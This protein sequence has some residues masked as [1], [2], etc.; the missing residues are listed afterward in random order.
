LRRIELCP[1]SWRLAKEA[2]AN[3]LDMPSEVADRGAMLHRAALGFE[4]FGELDAYDGSLV[5]RARAFITAELE[6]MGPCEICTEHRLTYHGTYFGTADIVA[7]AD[8]RAK[9]IDLKFGEG[10]LLLGHVERQQRAYAVG[11]LKEFFG[12]SECG[13][14]AY[15]VPEDQVYRRTYYDWQEGYLF[16]EV[17][18]LATMPDASRVASPEACHWCP[19]KSI[20]PEFRDTMAI[21]PEAKADASLVPPEQV[22]QLYEW[23]T[24][25]DQ[26]AGNVKAWIKTLSPEQLDAAGLTLKTQNV[27]SISSPEI[28]L[29]ILEESGFNAYD[30]RESLSVAL[31]KLEEIFARKQHWPKTESKKRL[32]SMLRLAGALTDSAR[33]TIKRKE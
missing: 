33:T 8:D 5:D 18:S 24:V 7:I 6:P 19:A 20:C 1:G 10:S 30:L 12:M 29:K 32:E 3:G 31:G 27:R 26:W 16:G 4:S 11:V 25:L 28:A 9:V 15:H 13:A 21:L 2:R 23:S 17:I 22:K 14:I